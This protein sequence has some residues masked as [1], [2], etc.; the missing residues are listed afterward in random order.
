MKFLLPNRGTVPMKERTRATLY[1]KRHAILLTGKILKLLAMKHTYLLIKEKRPRTCEWK[2][3]LYVSELNISI[4]HSLNKCL[5]TVFYLVTIV[6]ILVF[7]LSPKPVVCTCT[8][9]SLPF[10]MQP[11]SFPYTSLLVLHF[12]YSSITFPVKQFYLTYI[13]T[14]QPSFLNT[15]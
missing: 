3:K 15:F 13:L 1:L 8:S 2:Y 10:S 7:I 6:S 5:F 12:V 14:I 11:F 9:T 4:S